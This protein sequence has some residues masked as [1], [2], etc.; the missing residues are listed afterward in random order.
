MKTHLKLKIHVCWCGVWAGNK[1]LS[2]WTIQS[3]CD[4]IQPCTRDIVVDMTRIEAREDPHTTLETKCFGKFAPAICSQYTA[5]RKSF[6]FCSVFTHDYSFAI[7]GM[8]KES[9]KMCRRRRKRNPNHMHIPYSRTVSASPILSILHVSKWSCQTTELK[10]KIYHL[11]LQ[12]HNLNDAAAVMC[13][14]SLVNV[15]STRCNPV[16]LHDT[17]SRS[18]KIDRFFF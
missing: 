18:R 4:T 16:G 17:K 14:S 15:A 6:L 2:H 5:N 13:I 8:G 11:S 1:S 10:I 7:S 9:S 3:T 12:R